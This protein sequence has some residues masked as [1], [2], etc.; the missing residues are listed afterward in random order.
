MRN[1]QATDTHQFAVGSRSPLAYKEML[2]TP[3]Q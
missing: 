1:C 2:L 3:K